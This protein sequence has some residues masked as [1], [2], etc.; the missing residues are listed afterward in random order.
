[1]EGEMS[2]FMASPQKE[3][4]YLSIAN[5]IVDRLIGLGLSGRE[6]EAMLFVIRKTYGFN[7]KKDRI[8]LSQFE[9]SMGVRRS[10]VCKTINKLV[11][12]RIL[13]RSDGVYEFNKNWEQWVVAKRRL[14]SRQ[15]ATVAKSANASRLQDNRVVAKWR[16]T[17]D[18]ITKDITK[19]IVSS[20]RDAL[21]PSQ[22]AVSFFQSKQ[23]QEE[24]ALFLSKK[25]IDLGVCSAE[26]A[27]FV[28]YWTERTK[29]GK[30]QRWELQ[31]TFEVKRRIITWFGNV[32]KSAPQFNSQ[33]KGMVL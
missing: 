9:R 12:Y 19:D 5:E 27:K 14:G 8:S 25:G 6:F 24:C 26:I 17:K 18:T 3:N 10:V 11:A 21:T 7:K 29:D 1:M 28:G 32:K 30:R 23:D 31:K 2:F 16:H 13:A 22:Q 20:A 15:E 4:G 33:K